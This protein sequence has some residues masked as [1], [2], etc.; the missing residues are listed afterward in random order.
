M[1]KDT[2]EQTEVQFTTEVGR[3]DS[4]DC[5][6]C[7]VLEYDCNKCGIRELIGVCCQHCFNSRCT[8]RECEAVYNEYLFMCDE[9]TF[10]KDEMH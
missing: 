2:K 8:M 4:K 6:K 7:K 3:V 1:E 10:D 9:F 5:S